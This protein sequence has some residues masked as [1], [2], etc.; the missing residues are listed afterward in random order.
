MQASDTC[1]NAIKGFEGC[2]LS[3]YND[4]NGFPTVGYG[5]KLLPGESFP[6][7]ITQEQ[8]DALFLADIRPF[9]NQVNGL[10]LTL[11]QGQFDCLCSF[12]FNLGL[13]NL[14]TMLSH[15]I[16]QIPEQII[17]WTHASG[18]IQPGLLKRREMEL[19]W[20]NS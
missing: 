14:K 9:E 6:N 13:G 2:R 16:D 7:G 11:T 18:K 10:G 12:A 5:H 15:G 4:L 19:S 8:A 20:W 1:L 17:R 3:V